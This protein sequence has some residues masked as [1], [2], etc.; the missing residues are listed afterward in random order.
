[1][2]PKHNLEELDKINRIFFWNK[3]QD[4]KGMNMVSWNK[5]CM[6]QNLGGVGLRKAEAV[7]KAMQMKLLLKIMTKP[8]SVWV[9][10]INAKYLKN[11][12]VLQYT[13]KS[14]YS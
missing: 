1:M 11:Q 6:P 9:R 4:K 7:N 10:L 13:K 2:L 5:I 8:D 14:N 12:H 3:E